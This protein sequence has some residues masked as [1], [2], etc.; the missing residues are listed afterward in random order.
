MLVLPEFN[1][2]P[3]EKPRRHRWNKTTYSA[4]GG[5][6]HDFVK[7]PD[8][9]SQVLEDFRHHEDQQAVQTFYAFL[10]WI[11]GRENSLETNDC[12]LTEVEESRDNFVGS[13][14]IGGRV[15]LFF[16]HSILNQELTRIHRL[17][18]V[19]SFH[20]QTIRPDFQLGYF[21]ISIVPTT[22]TD[23]IINVD[24]PGHRLRVF[25]SAYD[26]SDQEVFDRLHVL[27][28]GLWDAMKEVVKVKWGGDPV[29]S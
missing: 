25:V 1:N 7:S 3:Y 27:F 26:N 22:Y 13:K 19:L 14:K 17:W 12:A 9:I 23:E 24:Y 8:L 29:V 6:Y 18:T 20:L 16:R 28:N 21:T 4:R 5:K 11:N 15:E 2:D 10:R